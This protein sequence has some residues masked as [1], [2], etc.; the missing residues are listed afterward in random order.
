VH[1]PILQLITQTEPLVFGEYPVMQ[2]AQTLFE[3]HEV[4]LVIL[5]PIQ[6]LELKT[7]NPY[8]QLTHV[9]GVS[10]IAQLAIVLL[11]H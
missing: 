11:M 8:V 4:Q 1:K 2:V 9:V 6:V 10:A 5:Q 3:L 7:K